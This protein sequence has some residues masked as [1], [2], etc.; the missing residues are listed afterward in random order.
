MTATFLLPF[1]PRA[2]DEVLAELGVL[3]TATGWKRAAIVHAMVLPHGQRKDLVCIS[4]IQRVTANRFAKRRIHGLASPHTVQAHRDAWQAAV[5]AGLTGPAALGGEV[6][7]PEGD[8]LEFYSRVRPRTAREKNG[9]DAPGADPFRSLETAV[10]AA[11]QSVRELGA[12]V[13]R[14]ATG[15]N[16]L[17]GDVGKVA[18]LLLEIE[19]MRRDL[20]AID[21]YIRQRA[22]VTRASGAEA[23]ARIEAEVAARQLVS[24]G[25]IA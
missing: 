6:V 15:A 12:A 9:G 21:T 19:W 7:L 5:D 8:W 11:G 17:N 4:A 3:A 20:D 22:A 2:A 25:A 1:S 23:L 10:R 24:T 13:D 18:P 16:D 14:V